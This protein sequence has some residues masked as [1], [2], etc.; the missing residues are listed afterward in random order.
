MMRSDLCDPCDTRLIHPLL[1]AYVAGALSARYVEP[2][3][4]RLDTV[5]TDSAAAVP[6][7]FVL[8]TGSDP[9]GDL[10]R[11]ADE[12][13]KQVGSRQDRRG[14]ARCMGQNRLGGVRQ[15]RQGGKRQPDAEWVG[16]GWW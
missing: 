5:F 7:I 3:A 1:Q 12:R 15:D 13:H 4:F 14:A 2:Q 6:L 10:L 9:M 11:F 8:S 16:L